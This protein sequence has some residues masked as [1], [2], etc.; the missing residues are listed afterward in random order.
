MIRGWRQSL[1]EL[2]RRGHSD[3]YPLIVFDARGPAG[4]E[5][6]SALPPHPGLLEFYQHCDGGYLAHMSFAGLRDLAALSGRWVESLQAYDNRGDILDPRQHVVWAEDAG[7]CPLVVDVVDGSVR[8]FQADGG[9]WESGHNTVDA[10]LTWLFN[11]SGPDDW[12]EA[13]A[14]L[15]RHEE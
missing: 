1:S 10:Y 12:Q 4:L 13:L 14:M 5:W 3:I 7:G 15:E 6:P 8:T 9:D 2:V 11:E